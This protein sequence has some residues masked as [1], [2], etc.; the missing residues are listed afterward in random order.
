MFNVLRWV[1][2]NERKNLG[3]IVPLRV[4]T[5]GRDHIEKAMDLPRGQDRMG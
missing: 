5:I 4:D 2:D 3:D 1:L